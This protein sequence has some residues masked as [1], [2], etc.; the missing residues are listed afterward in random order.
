MKPLIGYISCFALVTIIC[1]F[2]PEKL[3]SPLTMGATFATLAIAFIT[4]KIAVKSYTQVERE[5]PW[6]LT[7]LGN[8]FWLLERVHPTVA[9][10]QGYCIIDYK[11]NVSAYD[12]HLEMEFYDSGNKPLRYFIRGTNMVVKM[13][14]VGIGSSIA[15]FY[16]EHANAKE[17]VYDI[18]TGKE[19]ITYE[20]L[21]DIGLVALLSTL[22]AL[23]PSQMKLN[24]E[25]LKLRCGLNW[26]KMS[27]DQIKK[28]KDLL[29][30]GWSR[31]TLSKDEVQQQIDLRQLSKRVKVWQT[32]LY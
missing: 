23:Y 3:S 7:P 4:Y 15:L 2:S 21:K 1:L 29:R 10:I 24:W 25:I 12:P 5:S 8:N 31:S 26:N 30:F 17:A 6:K 22:Q 9:T 11:P 28:P 20:G 14:E 13:P 27:K 18:E 16:Q 32:S 19:K